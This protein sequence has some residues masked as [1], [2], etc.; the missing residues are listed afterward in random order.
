MLLL[1]GEKNVTEINQSV[2]VSQPALSQHLSRLRSEGILGSRRDQRQIYYFINN[3][4][5]KRLLEVTAEVAQ[6]R[7]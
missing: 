1:D 3:P 2:R 5:I 7:K 4:G 6:Q